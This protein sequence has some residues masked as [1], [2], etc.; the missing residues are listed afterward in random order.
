MKQSDLKVTLTIGKPKENI[1]FSEIYGMEVDGVKHYTN[2]TVDEAITRLFEIKRQQIIESKSFAIHWDGDLIDNLNERDLLKGYLLIDCP[3]CGGR[4]FRYN[5]SKSELTGAIETEPCL[6]CAGKKKVY[7]LG[8]Y[9]NF[10]SEDQN[11][12]STGR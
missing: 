6:T 1:D 3:K 9:F 8:R 2:L 5:P 10:Y 11:A 7:V 4:G 12:R